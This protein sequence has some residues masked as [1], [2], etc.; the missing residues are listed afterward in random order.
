MARCQSCACGHDFG[1]G[2]AAHFD[3]DR[4]EGLVE[5]GV[6]DRA[7]MRRGDQ[8][9]QPRPRFT[10]FPWRSAFRRPPSRRGDLR[11]GE[12]EVGE[13][14]DFALVHRDAAEDLGEI[15]AE[16]DCVSSASVS[17]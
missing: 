7:V 3:A 5:A 12:A 13:A 10:R 16:P 11:G 1:V 4:F 14:D 2:E 8:R 15:F 17:P 6:A 9:R